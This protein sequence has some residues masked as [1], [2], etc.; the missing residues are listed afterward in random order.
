MLLGTQD[1]NAGVLGGVGGAVA[2][3]MLGAPQIIGSMA[4]GM[5][6]GAIG[7]KLTATAGYNNYNKLKFNSIGP[8]VLFFWLNSI[9]STSLDGVLIKKAHKTET[10]T[11]AQIED[12]Q[13]VW[14]MIMVI[15]ILHEILLISQHPV[16][17]KL[18]LILFLIKCVC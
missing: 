8:R 14:I 17:G 13:S 11:D 4:G 10:Y 9:M 12:L 3:H 7:D 5:L 18:L 16:K 15:C 1:P 2:G 6:G